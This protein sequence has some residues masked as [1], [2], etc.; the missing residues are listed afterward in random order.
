MAAVGLIKKIV[1][2]VTC[3]ITIGQNVCE[4]MFGVNAPDLNLGIQISSVK[5]PIRSTSVVSG[6][7]SHCGTSA[8]YNHLDHCFVVIKDLQQSTRTRLFRVGWNVINNTEFKIIVL[9]W[10]FSL[11]LGVLVWCGVTRRDSTCLIFG[12]SLIRLEKSERVLSLHPCAKLHQ[13]MLARL[14]LSCV[15]PKSVSCTSNLSVQM[16]DYQKTL[17]STWC[18]FWVFQVSCKI[19]VL[20]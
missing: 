9:G 3:E 5:Q 15:R 20:K 12:F 6:Y 11:V 14:L 4:S 13:E 17:K 2:F 16:F 19:R 7:M 18:W 1:P 10:T 8:F